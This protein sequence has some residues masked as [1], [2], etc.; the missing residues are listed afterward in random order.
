[1]R[2]SVPGVRAVEALN[3]R[4]VFLISLDCRVWRDINQEQQFQNLNWYS[5][6]RPKDAGLFQVR[7][8]PEGTDVLHIL[9]YF[10]DCELRMVKPDVLANNQNEL[11]GL[12]PDDS[13]GEVKATFACDYS[14]PEDFHEDLEAVSAFATNAAYH[15]TPHMREIV[16]SCLIRMRLPSVALPMMRVTPNAGAVA[17]SSTAKNT[18]KLRRTARK[19][20]KRVR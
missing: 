7:K 20:G 2:H 6:V 4:D 17:P 12:Q 19:S 14:C 5:S 18:S 10:V 11:N 3:I 8:V 15:A 13:L 9:R 16:Q 1:V